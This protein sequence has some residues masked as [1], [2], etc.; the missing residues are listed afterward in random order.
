VS[1]PDVRDAY[2]VEQVRAAEQRLMALAPA[3]ALMQRAAAGLATACADLLGGVYGRRILVL[4]GSGNNGGDALFAGARLAARGAQVEAVL[5][6]PDAVHRPGLAALLG[7][8]G[9]VV[10]RVGDGA[11]SGDLVLDGI[12]G[13]GATGGLRADADAAWQRARQWADWV[14]AVDV[15]SGIGVD[16]GVVE[17]A[18]VVADLTVT[19]GAYKI[20]LLVGEGSRR[21]G[22]VQLVDIGI[23]PYLPEPTVRVLSPADVAGLLS[24][25]APGPDDHKY[26]RGVVGVAAGSGQYT[27]A[28][29]LAVAGASC[30]LAGMVRFDGAPEVA[31]L[32]RLQHPEVVIGAGQVQCWV[33]GSGGGGDAA[34]VLDRARGDGVPLVIDAD[35][36][37]SVTGPLGVPALLTP[38]AGELGRLMGVDRAEVERDPL[39]WA[40]EAA[41]RFEATVLLKGRRTVIA[42]GTGVFVNTTGNPWLGTA[43]AGDVLAGL[44]GALAA[45][46]TGSL[47]ASMAEPLPS[48]AAVG[49]WLHGAAAAYAS[50]GGPI[51]AGDVATALP[52]VIAD[53]LAGG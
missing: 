4:A 24:A 36:L 5:L 30:G 28:G 35:A 1:Q 3:N 33:V 21:A 9:R 40:A 22:A 7:A 14:V 49:A 41:S 42:D 26:T 31:D 25:A 23:G 29:L 17:G 27:G 51:T 19:F 43:G 44:L 18:S 47:A 48:V 50:Q 53:V 34:A 11:P 12:V 37:Q 38:H 15:P 52:A 46:M 2:S 45:S 39:R 32:V 20:G 10:P 13:I 8:G 16:D 6:S